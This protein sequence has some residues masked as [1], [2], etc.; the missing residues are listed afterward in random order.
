MHNKKPD[1][2]GRIQHE[3]IH[4]K[5]TEVPSDITNLWGV[6]GTGLTNNTPFRFML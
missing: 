3:S 2:I 4:E 1:G 6:R 5:L